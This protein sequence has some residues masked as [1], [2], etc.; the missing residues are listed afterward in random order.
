MLYIHNIWLYI[1]NI[2]LEGDMTMKN[3]IKYLGFLGFLGL[4]GYFTSNPGFYGFF[5]FFG[6][7]SYTR[8]T[9]DERFEANLNKA[10]RNAFL[11]SIIIF[12]SVII[13]VSFTSNFK[14]F[15]YAFA[16]GFAA[17]WILFFISLQYYELTG[18]N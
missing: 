18:T 12:A 1:Y 9:Q 14:A 13:Y 5:G 16:L 2:F 4:L 10:C 3:W 8:I 6:L 17:Q 15:S 7:F 11:L